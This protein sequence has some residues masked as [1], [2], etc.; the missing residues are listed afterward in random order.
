MSYDVELCRDGLPVLVTRHEEGGTYVLGGSK[1]AELNITYNYAGFYYKYLDREEGLRWLYGKTGE[2][3]APRLAA[4][5][6]HLGTETSD[7]Y[8]DSTPGNAGR[9]LH[10]LFKWAVEHPD[11]VWNGD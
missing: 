5:I 8:W 7:D 1:D 3:T 9:A 6:A 4:A 10:I 2:E 11:A